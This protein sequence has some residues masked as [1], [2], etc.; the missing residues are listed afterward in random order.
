[1]LE[2]KNYLEPGKY[3]NSSDQRI[4]NQAGDMMK[5]C[6]DKK[7]VID[8]T[9]HFVRDR[10]IYEPN[11]EKYPQKAS[12]VLVFGRGNA[13]D[14]ACL[15]AALFRNLG[16]P[17]GIK[18]LQIRDMKCGR[19]TGNYLIPNLVWHAVTD[20]Y[21]DGHWVKLD[22]CFDRWFAIGRHFDAVR[23]DGSHDALLPE[24]DWDGQPNYV[25][26]EETEL[27]TDFPPCFIE[28]C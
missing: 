7:Q 10:I 15:L 13:A 27:F 21:L 14:K 5:Y 1:M 22:A 28:F 19:K 23:F 12:E 16:I 2:V 18:F 26:I 6:S 9:F 4:V 24:K 8:R 17:A 11:V 20:I 3:I 25:I